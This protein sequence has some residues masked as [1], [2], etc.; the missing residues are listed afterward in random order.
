M[1]SAFMKQNCKVCGGIEVQSC[2]EED[3]LDDFDACG[4]PIFL[5]YNCTHSYKY[6]RKRIIDKETVF[7]DEIYI[8]WL[9]KQLLK[10]LR[11]YRKYKLVGLCHATD[12]HGFQCY[13]LP[14]TLREGRPV[15]R[16]HKNSAYYFR[17]IGTEYAEEIELTQLINYIIGENSYILPELIKLNGKY[18]ELLWKDAG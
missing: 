4:E 18:T 2:N 7:D 9:N 6:F 1:L 10:Q 14:K 16:A 13:L 12:H 8:Q 5:C 3:D 17:F 11:N 15:C